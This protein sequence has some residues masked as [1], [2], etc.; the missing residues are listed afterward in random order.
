MSP[1]DRSLVLVSAQ[2]Y[3]DVAMTDIKHMVESPLAN[4]QADEDFDRLDPEADE[5]TG[6]RIAEG[7]APQLAQHLVDFPWLREPSTRLST[8]PD[9]AGHAFAETLVSVYN[10]A[11]L[12]VLARASE[13]ARKRLET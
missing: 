11:Q 6:Q 12:D 5:P 8:S 13:L 4:P 7:I 3:D 1:S 2:L 9:V 10:A